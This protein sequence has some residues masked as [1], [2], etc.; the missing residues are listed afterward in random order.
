MNNK[1]NYPQGVFCWAELCT[2]NWKEGK[3]FYTS[4]FGWGSDDQPIGDDE[5]YTMLQ[6]QGDDIAAMYQMPQAQINDELPGY[7]LTYIAVEDVD[8]CAIKA[9]E[10]GA[11]IIAGPH[12]VMDAGRMLMLKD[13]AGATVALWQGNEHI[14]CKRPGELTTPYWHEMATR[15][16]TAS[17]N[18]YC[19]LLGWKSQLKPMDGMDYTLFLIGDKPVAGMI[20]MTDE[21]P[22]DVPPHWMIYFA[23]DSCDSYVDK[24]VDLGAQVCVPATDI[25]DVGR[26]SVIC[27]P[28]GSVFS[29]IEP[30]LD[31]L[32]A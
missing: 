29:I 21:W 15:D 9:K 25:E 17:S 31:E 3:A 6:K 19:E 28:Q 26:F 2:R 24:A 32:N 22:V 18:F 11:Q 12:N 30:A 14:G 1:N 20:E 4:L 7:W 5:Y 27:D 23:V 8:A 16:T 10:L 13:T